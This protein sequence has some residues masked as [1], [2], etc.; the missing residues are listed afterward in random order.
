MP[1]PAQSPL[2]HLCEISIVDINSRCWD[3]QTR[4]MKARPIIRTS[5]LYISIVQYR[6]STLSLKAFSS[7]SSFL[8]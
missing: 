8:R 1:F 2:F 3:G 7:G 4:S 5:Q 6:F